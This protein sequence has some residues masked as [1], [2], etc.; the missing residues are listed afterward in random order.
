MCQVAVTLGPI[1]LLI[2]LIMYVILFCEPMIWSVG[3]CVSKNF[4]RSEL[5]YLR[6][7]RGEILKS[8]FAERIIIS[9]FVWG[10]WVAMLAFAIG[11]ILKH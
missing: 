8:L 4:R 1:V 9:S 6:D 2:Q 3:I 11:F 10:F 7:E 5:N